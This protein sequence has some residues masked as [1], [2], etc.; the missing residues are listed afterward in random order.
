M[1]KQTIR[2]VHP[3][4]NETYS[5][6]RNFGELLKDAERRGYVDLDYDEGRGNYTVRLREE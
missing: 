4:F 6:Y 2:R 3:G 1:V 5:G